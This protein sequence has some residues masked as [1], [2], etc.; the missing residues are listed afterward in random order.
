MFIKIAAEA[1]ILNMVS[2]PCPWEMDPATYGRAA[3]S[4]QQQVGPLGVALGRLLVGRVAVGD[5]DA[6]FY[7]FACLRQK[8]T[9]AA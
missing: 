4:G 9:S 7:V 3:V 1:T 2:C 8:I 6:M 5:D